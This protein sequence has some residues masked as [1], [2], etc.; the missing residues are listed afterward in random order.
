MITNDRQYKITKAQLAKLSGW[1]NEFNVQETAKKVGSSVL[2]KAELI[3]LKSEVEILESQVQEYELLKSGA[4]S[5]FRTSS[6][7]ELHTMLIRARIAQNLSQ[8]KLAEIL[9]L[10]EQQ[11]QRYES[12]KYA[13]ASLERIVEIATALNIDFSGVAKINLSKTNAERHSASFDWRQFPIKDMYKRRWFENF[14]GTFEDLMQNG[15]EIIQEF[16]S[17]ITRKPT[18]ALHHKTIRSKSKLDSYALLA[19]ESRILHLAQNIQEHKQYRPNILTS[20]WVDKLRKLS[21]QTDGP[22]QARAMLQNAGIIL[23]V[24]PHLPNTY[25]DG[26][27]LLLNGITPV[28]AMTLRY[29][30]LDNF[31]YVLFHELAHV[32]KHLKKDI[33]ENIFDDLDE[34]TTDKIEL[35]ADKWALDALISSKE[36]STALPRFIQSEDVVQS[37]ASEIGIHPAIIAGRIRNESKNYII[38]NDLIGQNEVRK[39]FPEVSFGI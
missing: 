17:V 37:F 3:A 11:I 32:I 8:S 13:S 18:L 24:E 19:W 35:E 14:R 15:E 16:T 2:A 21:A 27:A 33:L 10:K 38:L 39:Q 25:L 30:R 5:D 31:W 26:A 7:A 22:I 12:Q 29:D 9:G 34:E 4:I 36:W 23:I 1:I 6:L 28:I 20:E